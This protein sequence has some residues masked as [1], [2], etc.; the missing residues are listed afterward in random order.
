MLILGIFKRLDWFFKEQK[1][2]YVIGV[3]ALFVT[4][5]M[6]IVPPKVIGSIVDA[7][8]QRNLKPDFFVS[9]AF[10]FSFKFRYAISDALC[11][12][13][14]HIW[15]VIYFRKA[16]QKSSFSAFYEDGSDVLCQ[17]SRR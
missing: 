6:T 7:I 17:P 8:S 3:L 11:L 15:H 14:I 9:D 2:R 16:N 12:E 1:K 4:A 10:D 5:I 13:K